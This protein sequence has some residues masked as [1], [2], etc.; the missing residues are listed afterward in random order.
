MQLLLSVDFF[1]LEALARALTLDAPASIWGWATGADSLSAALRCFSFLEK[2]LSQDCPDSL[3]LAS[4]P[5]P[6]H[7]EHQKK[8]G[9]QKTSPCSTSGTH[10]P[11]I[12]LWCFLFLSKP[13]YAWCCSSDG[14]AEEDFSGQIGCCSHYNM[15]SREVE[16]ALAPQDT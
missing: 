13:V 15:P 5:S 11:C 6:G 2:F 3:L 16:M 14:Q 12:C 7:K 8:A 1:S 9:F 4:Q 10:T